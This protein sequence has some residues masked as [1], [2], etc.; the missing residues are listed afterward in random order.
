LWPRRRN[1]GNQKEAT[2]PPRLPF[3]QP[4]CGV[5]G[6][7][8]IDHHHRHHRRRHHHHGIHSSYPTIHITVNVDSRL[9]AMNTFLLLLNNTVLGHLHN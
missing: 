1:I 6:R 5:G 2:V 4:I 3:F 8:S 9:A 7:I